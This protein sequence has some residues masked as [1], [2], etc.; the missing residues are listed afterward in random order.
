MDTHDTAPPAAQEEHKHDESW[1]L[2]DESLAR[3]SGEWSPEF[4]TGCCTK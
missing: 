3:L 1:E 4:L 2:S